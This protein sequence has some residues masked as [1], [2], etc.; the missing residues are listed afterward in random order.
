VEEGRFRD[1]LFF[2]INVIPVE[3]PPLRT[4]GNDILLL[5][6][7]FLEWFAARSEKAVAGM[8][9]N[10]AKKLLAYPWP[11]NV[12]ELRNAI[13]HAVVLTR[14]EQILVEDLPKRVRAYR[15]SQVWVDSDNP[16]ELLPMAEVERRYVRHV[17]NAVQGNRTQAARLL[18][19]DRK[20]LYRKL[21][22][23]S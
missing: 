4:R 16:N 2:R 22:Q 7:H 11:G 17:L 23:D 1:D 9:Q 14:H 18:G 8:S 12:R 10:V 21:Q 19:F 13:E 20:T 6:Q 15:G 3:L 5:A